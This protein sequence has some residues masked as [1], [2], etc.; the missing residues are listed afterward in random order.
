MA[1]P[2]SR[3][4]ECR[5]SS[6]LREIPVS[7]YEIARQAIAGVLEQASAANI[8]RQDTLHAMLVSVVDA[9]K[10]EASES[11]VRDALEFL[12]DNLDDGRDYEFM[13]P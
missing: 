13:R 6:S 1:P 10:A 11:G 3:A 4:V 12:L 7:S 5:A 2:G 8:S 9:Y